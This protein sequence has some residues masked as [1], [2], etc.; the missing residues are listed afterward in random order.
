MSKS[1]NYADF[2]GLSLESSDDY[3][4]YGYAPG[5]HEVETIGNHGSANAATSIECIIFSNAASAYE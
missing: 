5:L 1:Y 4:P 3:E 2:V